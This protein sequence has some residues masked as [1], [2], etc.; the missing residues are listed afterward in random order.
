MHTP[1]T[2]TDEQVGPGSPVVALDAGVRWMD[3]GPSDSEPRECP[4]APLFLEHHCFIAHTP[5]AEPLPLN[6]DHYQNDKLQIVA[7]TI[8]FLSSGAA[9]SP[10]QP[11]IYPHVCASA[12]V[13]IYGYQ[14]WC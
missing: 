1:I 13:A 2:P 5:A 6:N 8:S 14:Y 10:L 7:F 12:Q 9:L 11:L 4:R 3:D